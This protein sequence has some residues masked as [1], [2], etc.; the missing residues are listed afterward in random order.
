[1]LDAAGCVLF[2]NDHL[3]AVVGRARAEMVGQDWIEMAVPAGERV[4]R[5]DVL[6]RGIAD[7]T[8]TGQREYNL[9]T[10]T[11]E[12]RHLSW[13]SVVQRDASGDV[14][15]LASIGYDVTEAYRVEADRFLLAAAV[16]QT[17]D[18]VIVTDPAADIVFVN[19]A[20]ERISGYASADVIGTRCSSRNAA[21]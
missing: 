10:A 3:L 7:G 9:I 20:F 16:Q 18:A 19:P 5:R 11:G 1:M 14:A 13:T 8:L 6:L 15:G 17:A 4:A 2:I 12:E 21:P